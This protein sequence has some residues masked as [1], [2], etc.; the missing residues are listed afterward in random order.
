[1]VRPGRTTDG[2]GGIVLN[3]TDQICGAPSKKR[4]TVI[5]TRQNE[6]TDRTFDSIVSEIMTDRIDSTELEIANLTRTGNVLLEG[7]N[8]IKSDTKVPDT[9]RQSWYVTTIQ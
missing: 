9:G 1:M 5:N 8:L 7:E 2:A 4:I 3:F 6:S